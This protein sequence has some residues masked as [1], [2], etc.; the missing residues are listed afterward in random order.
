MTEQLNTNDP[1]VQAFVAHV[2]AECK[3]KGIK[4]ELRKSKNLTLAKGMRCSGYF[5]ESNT[6]LVVAVNNPLSLGVF[7]H[8]FGHFTQWDEKIPIWDKACEAMYHIEEWL[9]GKEV[10]NIKKWIALARDLELDNE[11]RSVKLIKQFDLP[12]DIDL[13]IKRANAYVLFYNWM[14]ITRKWSTPANSPYRNQLLL[15][16]CSNKFNMK[17]DKLSA[18]LEKVFFIAEI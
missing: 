6:R 1:R 18:K 7:V 5:D 17:Y 13:Y 14:L 12:I 15:D 9:S 16:T 8:E 4:V 2:K 11:K 3:R 10:K